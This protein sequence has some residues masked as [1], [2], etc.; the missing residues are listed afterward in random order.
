MNFNL[1]KIDA[2]D[3][4]NSWLK[5]RYS[6][7]K[8][9]DGDV[10]WSKAQNIGRGQGNSVWVSEKGKNLT[11][12][13]YKEFNDLAIHN[14]FLLSAIVSLA[15]AVTLKLFRIPKVCVKWP[16]DIMSGDKKVC[17]ILIENMFKTSTLQASIIGVGLNVNQNHFENLFQASSM[18]KISG[19][20]YDL[21][22]VMN[23]FLDQ[24]NQKFKLLN[25]PQEQIIKI[26][27]TSLYRRN[28]PSTFE[29]KGFLF[30]GV[31]R[32]V[33]PQGLLKVE[34]EDHRIC[35]YNLKQIKLKN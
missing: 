29:S 24:L 25:Q 19:M 16:N 4:T 20:L 12:S 34:Q 3:S 6:T 7:N 14:P 13:I 10:V 28:K 15:L 30:S 22:E 2:T 1:I 33:T 32:G 11:I 8:C 26:Y 18:S 31:I 23:C 21:D 17:G 27:E 35:F 5:E 9:S